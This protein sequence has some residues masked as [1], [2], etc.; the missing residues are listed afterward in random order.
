MTESPCYWK[1]YRVVTLLKKMTE[2]NTI[3]KMAESSPYWKNGRVF[4][5]IG[6]MVESSPY[7]K[8]G[9]VFPLLEK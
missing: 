7:W 9:R 3:G 4:P 2:S 1:N 6:K 8:N 5:P